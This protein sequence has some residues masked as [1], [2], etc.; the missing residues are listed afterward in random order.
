MGILD[1]PSSQRDRDH[2]RG[3]GA[4]G[5]RPH[6]GVV[7]HTVEL[8]KPAMCGILYSSAVMCNLDW[9]FL[10]LPISLYH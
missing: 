2:L 5:P 3:R 1:L 8:N 9:R 6:E 4:V 7:A 10:Y